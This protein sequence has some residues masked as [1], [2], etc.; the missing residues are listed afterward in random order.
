MSTLSEKELSYE[1]SLQ[2]FKLKYSANIVISINKCY[3][4]FIRITQLQ[5]VDDMKDD[6]SKYYDATKIYKRVY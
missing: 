2:F 4:S 3:D 6:L 1:G 5:K